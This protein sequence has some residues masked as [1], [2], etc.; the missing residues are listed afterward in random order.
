M[1][2]FFR[3]LPRR[4][5]NAGS[6]APEAFGITTISATYGLN[7]DVGMVGGDPQFGT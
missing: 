7:S 4:K 2:S 1:S 3:V 5:R 6:V